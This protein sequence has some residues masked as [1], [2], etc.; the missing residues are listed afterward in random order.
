[1]T[2]EGDSAV[3]F[4]GDGTAPLRPEEIVGVWISGV[5]ETKRG[6]MSFEFRIGSDGVMDVIGRQA[7]DSAVETFRRS[8]SY[9]L[10]GD[11]L[12]SPAVNEGRPVRVRLHSGTLVLMIDEVLRFQLRRGL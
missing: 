11:L 8:G 1:M 5:R 9:R 2:P 6:A 3:N 7:Y 12:V 10:E 4:A